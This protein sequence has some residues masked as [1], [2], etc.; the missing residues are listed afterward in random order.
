MVI[1]QVSEERLKEM[2]QQA[3]NVAINDVVPREKTYYT[4]QEVAEKIRISLPTV[5]S[6]VNS[7]KIV[8]HKIGG[9]SLFDAEEIEQAIAE[10]K[11]LKYGRK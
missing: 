11:I 8:C 10:K 1:I 2:L 6:L 9:R 5:H 7:G 3:I 4:R